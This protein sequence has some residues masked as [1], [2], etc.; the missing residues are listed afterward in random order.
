M[1]AIREYLDKLTKQA[2]REAGVEPTGEARQELVSH[3][4]ELAAT[5]AMG[6]ELTLADIDAAWVELAPKAVYLL[7]E[8]PNRAGTRTTATNAPGFRGGSWLR[9]FGAYLSDAVIVMGCFFVS[10]L[11]VHEAWDFPQ[12]DAV[13]LLSIF[14][15]LIILF[16]VMV[17]ME[18]RRGGTPGKLMF[19]LRTVNR[20]GE[21]PSFASAFIMTA[22]KF[23]PPLLVLDV[24]LGLVT[25]FRDRARLTERLG[26]VRVIT[27]S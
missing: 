7:T 26:Q 18:V 14:I 23:F 17:M 25:G 20:K 4:F 8:D 21:F 22:P 11:A 10:A 5:R 19:R 13:E 15:V 9:R 16:L 24:L 3:L 12:D 27:I 6:R 1:N 2:A